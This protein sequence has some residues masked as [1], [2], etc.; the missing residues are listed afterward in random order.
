MKYPQ[1]FE[2]E[3]LVLYWICCS[4]KNLSGKFYISRAIYCHKM[5]PQNMFYIIQSEQVIRVLLKQE[6]KVA[7]VSALNDV[8]DYARSRLIHL[9][10]QF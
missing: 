3:M 8:N 1:P 5:F 4:D 10:L 2:L 9:F 7:F 6:I